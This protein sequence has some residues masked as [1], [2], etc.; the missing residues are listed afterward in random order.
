MWDLGV[1][2]IVSTE[3]SGSF[4]EALQLGRWYEH[5]FFYSRGLE[6]RVALTTFHIH[7]YR[8]KQC[9]QT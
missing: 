4:F 1:F 6:L 5:I 2:V 7:F 9:F 3:R 8:I